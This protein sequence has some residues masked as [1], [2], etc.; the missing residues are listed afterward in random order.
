MSVLGISV[1]LSGC[2]AAALIPAAAM[3]GASSTG[4][5]TADE[6]KLTELT[7]RNFSVAPGQVKISNIKK[8][9]SLIS[10]SSIYYDVSLTANGQVKAL[11]CMMTS[12]LWMNSSPL[13]ARPGE[14]LTGGGSGDSCNA[15]LRAAGRC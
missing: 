10:G 3:V 4:V 8:D 9:N 11:H 1:A 5:G 2:V 13:C 12:S 15:L 14:S 7:A 6:Q